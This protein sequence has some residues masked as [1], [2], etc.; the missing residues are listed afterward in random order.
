MHEKWSERGDRE[1]AGQKSLIK[2]TKLILAGG[3]SCTVSA[4]LLLLLPSLPPS[5]VGGTGPRPISQL[6]RVLREQR[7]QLLDVVLKEDAVLWYNAIGLI[8]K[9]GPRENHGAIK[10]KNR[11]SPRSLPFPLQPL[12]LSLSLASLPKTP[13]NGTL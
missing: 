7:I 1:R 9:S 11:Q 4:C 5:P 10:F 6:R 3:Q 8:R 2:A 13:S 12:I